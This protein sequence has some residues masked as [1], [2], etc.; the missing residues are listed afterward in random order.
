MA[1]SC[2]AKRVFRPLDAPFPP[3]RASHTYCVQDKHQRLRNSRYREQRNRVG[4]L[5]VEEI[6]IKIEPA[7]RVGPATPLIAILT[8]M[9]VENERLSRRRLLSLAL[10][11]RA[12]SDGGWRHTL[13]GSRGASRPP[14]AVGLPPVPQGPTR[15]F[16]SVPVERKAAPRACFLHAPSS[17]FP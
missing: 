6:L 13:Q 5:G 16:L 3:R 2:W 14:W 15:R 9:Q 12:A 4:T 1:A 8:V 10:T 17:S 11:P 7:P